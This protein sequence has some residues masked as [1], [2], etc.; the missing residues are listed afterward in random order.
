MRLGSTVTRWISNVITIVVYRGLS[1]SIPFIYTF[2]PP[3]GITGPDL[4][5]WKDGEDNITKYFIWYFFR[6]THLLFYPTGEN[7]CLH[8]GAQGYPCDQYCQQVLIHPQAFKYFFVNKLFPLIL[9]NE[10]CFVYFRN[11]P[12]KPKILVIALFCRDVW[13]PTEKLSN[14]G[15]EVFQFHVDDVPS[16]NIAPFFR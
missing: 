13:L 14:M 7:G 4:G 1:S 8:A 3:V 16:A 10:N 9:T 15:V 2:F 12:L 5:Q 11:K 6:G